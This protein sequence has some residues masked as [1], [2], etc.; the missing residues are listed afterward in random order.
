I[1]PP[2]RPAQVDRA[3][4]APKGNGT[5]SRLLL[6]VEGVGKSF[7]G[8]RAVDGGSFKVAG[9]E[10]VG[11][12]GPNGSGKTTL[13]NGLS[14]ALTASSGTI[15]LGDTVISG[16]RPHRIARLGLARTFQ[17]VRVMSDLTAAENVA[18]AMLFGA[19]PAPSGQAGESIGQ[20]LDLV[21]LC[22]M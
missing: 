15:R 19:G 8:L 3:A 14:G 7:S 17:L 6:A 20:L 5:E 1:G 2:R 10:I 9:G 13:L 12:I 11:I 22:A 16:L 21:G 4:P 18:A